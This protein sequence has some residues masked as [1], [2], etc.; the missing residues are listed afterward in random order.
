MKN[1]NNSS[2]SQHSPTL[3]TVATTTR[4]SKHHPTEHDNSENH[5]KGEENKVH[6]EKLTFDMFLFT[7]QPVRRSTS[8]HEISE[9]LDRHESEEE[10][11]KNLRKKKKKKIPRPFPHAP[12]FNFNNH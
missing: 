8:R 7:H 11:E 1:L 5:S 9:W 4:S 2:N 12:G 6:N 3:S 10:T